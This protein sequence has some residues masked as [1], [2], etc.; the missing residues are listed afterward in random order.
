M[1]PPR[2]S[3]FKEDAAA[4]DRVLL[5]CALALT[6]WGILCIYSAA[7]GPHG[8]GGDF[9]LCQFGFLGLSVATMFAIQIGRAHV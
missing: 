8:R 6:L 9:A 3:S 5:A 1:E 7:A 4:M 2:L